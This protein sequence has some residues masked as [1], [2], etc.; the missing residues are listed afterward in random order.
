[1]STL[2]TSLTSGLEVLA[3]HEHPFEDCPS[4]VDDPLW[5]TMRLLYELKLPQ[6]AALK[7]KV[8]SL[9]ISS[10]N[11][12]ITTSDVGVAALAVDIKE[13]LRQVYARD[14]A[15][16]SYRK[17]LAAQESDAGLEYMTVV[18]GIWCSKF[19][20]STRGGSSSRHRVS[21]NRELSGP[22]GSEKISSGGLSDGS[23]NYSPIGLGRSVKESLASI[24]QQVSLLF[25][26]QCSLSR[27]S[28]DI[29]LRALHNFEK[30][31]GLK[32]SKFLGPTPDVPKE[33]FIID[34]AGVA[35]F[36][37]E[38]LQRA[39]VLQNA[40]LLS[41]DFRIIWERIVVHLHESLLDR[42]LEMLEWEAILILRA[43]SCSN[44]KCG[45]LGQVAEMCGCCNKEYLTC[46]GKSDVVES[47][48]FRQDRA[49][50]KALF[51]D[52]NPN[53]MHD[54]ARQNGFAVAHPEWYPSATASGSASPPPAS[55]RALALSF[56]F[57]NQQLFGLPFAVV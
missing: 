22:P 44:N 47:V 33:H 42:D 38:M 57:E 28:R 18:G 48:Q 19:V 1:M 55:T 32:V 30:D 14:I 45:A 41:K 39:F 49:V 21:R 54:S 8:L 43:N 56:I 20:E 7:N 4:K 29:W 34:G 9:Q 15:F 36:V 5:E 46:V 31:V 53:L 2:V 35:L 11:E 51:V 50:A 12:S 23:P 37:F 40:T 6:I 26:P 52:A 27:E 3:L 17:L 25:H 10:C 13:N 16:I 24:S